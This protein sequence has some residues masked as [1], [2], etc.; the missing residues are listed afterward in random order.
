MAHLFLKNNVQFNLS[1]VTK[2]SCS[3]GLLIHKGVF[4]RR[5]PII[6]FWNVQVMIDSRKKIKVKIAFLKFGPLFDRLSLK[7]WAR[8]FR[9]TAIPPP[10]GQILQS[11]FPL[12]CHRQ[13]NTCSEKMEK[14]VFFANLQ[15]STIVVCNFQRFLSG[16]WLSKYSMQEA[17]I[18]QID[19]L[20][21]LHSFLWVVASV[22]L[23][24]KRNK[25]Q[26][27][28]FFNFGWSRFRFSSHHSTFLLKRTT[29]LLWDSN[30]EVRVE[31]KLN[32]HLTTTAA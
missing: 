15:T 12:F 26:E 6:H 25:K 18:F 10:S 17:V 13:T 14:S 3:I 24:F 32:D 11:L 31:G 16:K 22:R 9:Q 7:F 21:F 2:C 28:D 29:R 30:W 1:F 8:G 20:T 4:M 19:P 23:T 27:D 5:F